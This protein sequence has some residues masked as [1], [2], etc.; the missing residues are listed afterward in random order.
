MKELIDIIYYGFYKLSV[1]GENKWREEL[2]APLS[3]ATRP[4][5]TLQAPVFRTFLSLN[6]N[7]QEIRVLI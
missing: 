1:Y 7:Y 6:F 5:A 3:G 4:F 2:R